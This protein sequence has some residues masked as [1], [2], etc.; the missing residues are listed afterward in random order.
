MEIERER[1]TLCRSNASHVRPNP[2]SGDPV[3]RV[4]GCLLLC[5]RNE[6]WLPRLACF[7]WAGGKGTYLLHV[8][9]W[10]REETEERKQS[11]C[12]RHHGEYRAASDSRRLQYLQ[13]LTLPWSRNRFI[14]SSCSSNIDNAFSGRKPQCILIPPLELLAS[15]Q[16]RIRQ[17]NWWCVQ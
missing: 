13:Y 5:C 10:G 6:K 2:L 15:S 7:V 17:S 12:G 9:M 16:L 4:R 3:I 8:N 1:E 14:F 11:W